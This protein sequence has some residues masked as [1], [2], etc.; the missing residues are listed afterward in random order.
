M[1]EFI[2]VVDWLATLSG[3]S[4]RGKVKTERSLAG[5]TLLFDLSPYLTVVGESVVLDVPANV[6]AGLNW[7]IGA[8]DLEL[9]DSNPAHDVRFI[10]GIITTDPEATT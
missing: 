10:Q 5:G 6:T 8:Y 3:Y 9:F 7:T 1:A 4:A 2:P